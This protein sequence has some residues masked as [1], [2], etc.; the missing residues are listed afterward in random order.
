[1]LLAGI[2]LLLMRKP[3]AQGDIFK[4]FLVAYSSW[5]LLID[6]LKPDPLFWAL[7]ST[8]W[9]CLLVLLYYSPDIK[10]WLTHTPVPPAA[11]AASA[12]NR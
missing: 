4:L 6:F 1:M 2:L 12:A 3:Y 9:A 8:Q 11:S 7:R 5:R 10:R